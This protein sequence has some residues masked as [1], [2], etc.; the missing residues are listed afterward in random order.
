MF[1]VLHAWGK[2]ENCTCLKKGMGAL[3]KGNAC[4]PSCILS[5]CSNVNRNSLARNVGVAPRGSVKSIL[6]FVGGLVWNWKNPQKELDLGTN[7]TLGRARDESRSRLN[8]D[9]DGYVYN[10]PAIISLIQEDE[11]PPNQSPITTKS[12]F[13]TVE[14]YV[15]AIGCPLLVNGSM[16]FPSNKRAGCQT[17]GCSPI[18]MGLY[19][20]VRFYAKIIGGLTSCPRFSFPSEFPHI[21]S[22]SFSNGKFYRLKD[23]MGRWT[24]ACDQRSIRA[25]LGLG[26]KASQLRVSQVP[27]I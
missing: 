13:S 15:R 3:V 17:I 25:P 5:T 6:D 11:K 24:S 12:T 7:G 26:T 9:M 20:V 18:I 23:S 8:K 1:V 14:R 19:S 27:R 10:N 22:G 16:K 4:L 2:E 21:R